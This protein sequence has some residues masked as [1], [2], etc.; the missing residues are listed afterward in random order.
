MKFTIFPIWF[1]RFEELLLEEDRLTKE[2]L[3]ANE[4]VLACEV[5]RLPKQGSN[6]W[7]KNH[8]EGQ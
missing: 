5:R 2:C 1:D 7:D 8:V 4:A 6:A 3:A